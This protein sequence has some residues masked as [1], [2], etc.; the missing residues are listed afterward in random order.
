MRYFVVGSLFVAVARRDVFA[1]CDRSSAVAPLRCPS[2]FPARSL[3]ASCVFPF[4]SFVIAA[5]LIAAI[6]ISR[7]PARCRPPQLIVLTSALRRHVCR[8]R[9][10]FSPAPQ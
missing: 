2:A 5:S 10:S 1:F 8:Q 7:S 3:R 4:S 6:T 9:R